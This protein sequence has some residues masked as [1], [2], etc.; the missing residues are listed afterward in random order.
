MLSMEEA[1]VCRVRQSTQSAWT[2]VLRK[3]VLGPTVSTMDCRAEED[4]DVPLQAGVAAA[5]RDLA[6][7]APMR[8]AHH[9]RLVPG[10]GRL[11][12]QGASPVSCPP[13][14]GPSLIAAAGFQLPHT[15]GQIFC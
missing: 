2:P 7:P 12:A 6:L 15:D 10:V 5:Q 11:Q 1:L 8:H 14:S 4:R 13:M 3:S 9:R